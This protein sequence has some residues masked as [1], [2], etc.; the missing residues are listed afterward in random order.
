MEN[1]DMLYERESYYGQPY[2]ITT[3]FFDRLDSRGKLLDIGCGQG[4][5]AI[6]LAKQGYEVTGI[7]NSGTGLA[8]F[9]KIA[10]KE[11]LNIKIVNG[12]V[13]EFDGFSEFDIIYA[14]TFFKFLKKD[15]KKESALLNKIL[16]NL[17]EGGIFCNCMKNS[18]QSLENFTDIFMEHPSAFDIMYDNVAQYP[19]FN[20]MRRVF[21]IQKI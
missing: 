12:D 19:E 18:S 9:E 8:Q 3:N 1:Y 20:E 15:L 14:D 5:N 13:Y 11:K 16:D 2:E 7:D 10:E 21:I 6:M 4:R 17:K